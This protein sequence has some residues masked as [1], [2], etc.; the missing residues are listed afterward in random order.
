MSTPRARLSARTDGADFHVVER[1]EGLSPQHPPCLGEHPQNL[2]LFFIPVESDALLHSQMADQSS[3]FSL[4][5]LKAS[6]FP[7]SRE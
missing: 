2:F 7:P 1:A 3:A 4:D 6:G 5:G